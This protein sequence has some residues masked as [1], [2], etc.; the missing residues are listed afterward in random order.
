M[1][2]FQHA[3]VDRRVL[4]IEKVCKTNFLYCGYCVVC[5]HKLSCV[6]CVRQRLMVKGGVWNAAVEC[7]A[8]SAA[9]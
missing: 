7:H 8:W 1:M 2:R 3:G 9:V 4:A 6:N 5:I